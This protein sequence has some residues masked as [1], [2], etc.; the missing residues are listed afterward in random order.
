MRTPNSLLRNWRYWATIVP[1][2]MTTNGN[3]SDASLE[4][5]QAVSIIA[6]CRSVCFTKLFY[7]CFT[8]KPQSK[9]DIVLRMKNKP[10]GSRNIAEKREIIWGRPTPAFKNKIGALVAK[11]AWT[12]CEIRDGPEWR[13]RPG[14]APVYKYLSSQLYIPSMCS[15][16][17]FFALYYRGQLLSYFSSAAICVIPCKCT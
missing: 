16:V 9:E 10:F 12:V 15:Q 11:L 4:R 6:P 13:C 14:V 7:C 8:L 1:V 3:L 17:S 2:R 5:L